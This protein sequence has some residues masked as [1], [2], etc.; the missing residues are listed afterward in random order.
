MEE[1]VNE[2]SLALGMAL[3]FFL[4]CI[5]I[6]VAVVMKGPKT[7]T[8]SVV[9]VILQVV[10]TLCAFSCLGGLQFILANQ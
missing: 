4:G 5:G 7:L 6:V 3:G 2:G 8:G 1:E 10:M 9:G